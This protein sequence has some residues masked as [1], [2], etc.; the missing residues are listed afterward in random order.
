LS[1]VPARSLR[2]RAERRATASPEADPSA[3]TAPPRKA[4][5]GERRGR[6]PLLLVI[7]QVRLADGAVATFRHAVPQTPPDRP[8]RLLALVA[9]TGLT[10]ALLAGWAV[11]RLTR[12]L[13]TLA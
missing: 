8:L 4:R 3:A 10:V 6:W 9:V 13:A 5:R 11:R 12:P 1:L 2:M 7:A